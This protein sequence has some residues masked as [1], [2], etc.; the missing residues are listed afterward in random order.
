MVGEMNNNYQTG[1]R[2]RI[3]ERGRIVGWAPQQQ[4][5]R[6]SSYKSKVDDNQ[7]SKSKSMRKSDSMGFD[8]QYAD[9]SD[10]K[11]KPQRFK[12]TISR[13]VQI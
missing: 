3:H 4:E 9:E 11:V 8:L 10:Y 12:S 13:F 1:Y 7:S 5:R 2:T 6:N